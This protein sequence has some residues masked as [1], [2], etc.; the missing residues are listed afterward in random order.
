MKI[1]F[2]FFRECFLTVLHMY[3]TVS[4]TKYLGIVCRKVKQYFHIQQIFESSQ[5]TV[6]AANLLG[7]LFTRPYMISSGIFFSFDLEKT[8]NRDHSLILDGC[9][10]LN[11]AIQLVPKVFHWIQVW[12]LDRTVQ[13]INSVVTI[14]IYGGL[15]NMIDGAVIQEE[16]WIQ[17]IELI[18]RRK[19][20]VIRNSAVSI[21]I[22]LTMNWEKSFIPNYEK[23][24]KNIIPLLPKLTVSRMNFGLPFHPNGIG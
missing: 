15:R 23:H 5:E 14:S 6:T 18:Q 10:L 11:S 12:S 7:M 24:L 3:Y 8:D 4:T 17:A 22:V 1:I 19:C 9:C 21:G 20:I 16:M 2:I 13:S